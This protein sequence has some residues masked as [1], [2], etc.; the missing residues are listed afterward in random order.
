MENMIHFGH[1]MGRGPA[2]LQCGSEPYARM[3]IPCKQG[4]FGQSISKPAF[5]QGKSGNS[6]YFRGFVLTYEL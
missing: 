4:I 2:Y 5:E 1:G 6:I 3:Y